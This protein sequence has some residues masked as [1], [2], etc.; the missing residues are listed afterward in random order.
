MHPTP[1]NKYSS[2]HYFKLLFHPQYKRQ[3]LTA[4]QKSE[5]LQI[6]GLEIYGG[7]GEHIRF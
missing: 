1:L 6:V 3:N 7:G 2:R 5:S 4:I